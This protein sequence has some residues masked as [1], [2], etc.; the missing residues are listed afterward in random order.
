MDEPG[1]FGVTQQ[2]NHQRTFM[3]TSRTGPNMA[4]TL[5]CATNVKSSGIPLQE[6]AR[7]SARSSQRPR[8]AEI[9]AGA[10]DRTR[11]EPIY[12]QL[13][14]FFRSAIASGRFPAG[15]TL[16]PSR[17]LAVQLGV[18][19]ATIV[20]VYDI[21][22]SEDLIETTVGS[23]TVVR[24]IARQAN[25]PTVSAAT[26]ARS[27]GIMEP[28]RPPA[29]H[30]RS[31]TW[32]R[33]VVD[34][35]L[36]APPASHDPKPAD[37]WRLRENI[38][39]YLL[40][41]RGL[42]C[43]PEQVVIASS[44]QQILNLIAKVARAD[45]VRFHFEPLSSSRARLAFENQ[46]TAVGTLP[47]FLHDNPSGS[48][49]RLTNGGIFTAPSCHYP[50]GVSLKY[51]ARLALA[52]AL[53]RSNLWAIEDARDFEFLEADA[54]PTLH[55][56]RSGRQT[57]HIGALSTVLLPFVSLAYVVAPTSIAD[58]LANERLAADDEVAAVILAA[59]SEMLE[60]GMFHSLARNARQTVV[61]RRALF[62]LCTARHDVWAL[63]DADARRGLHGLLWVDAGDRLDDLR[64]A[65]AA[66]DAGIEV[67]SATAGR[68]GTDAALVLGFAAIRD[69]VID[70]EVARVAAT[71]ERA[72][73]HSA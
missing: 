69:D 28:R 26:T 19:R 59:A 5:V 55:E 58:R 1:Q 27:G 4:T 32:R 53:D 67:A 57:F 7:A 24:A 14:R 47:T 51:E 9:A 13:V 10:I 68:T 52:Q 33:L 30:I 29:D 45:A 38:A 17:Q 48:V 63:P 42:R 35:T 73:S 20:S 18:S 65:I 16:P 6:V 62:D 46:G 61:R 72:L 43:A 49:E 34:R 56:L 71:V 40:L 11:H 25:R 22:L 37:L 66:L 41:S 12:L 3:R 44:V 70:H 54:T 31:A 36:R 21:L 60:T 8:V 15:V 2:T 64:A 39:T 23:G 50:L